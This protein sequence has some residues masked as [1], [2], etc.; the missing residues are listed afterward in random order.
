[1]IKT[2]QWH[3]WQLSISSWFAPSLSLEIN[4]N[5]DS[6]KLTPNW[7][8]IW[9]HQHTLISTMNLIKK[10]T[11]DWRKERSLCHFRGLARQRLNVPMYWGR[12]LHLSPSDQPVFPIPWTKQLVEQ[13]VSSP[14]LKIKITAWSVTPSYGLTNEKDREGPP[15][16]SCECL[17]VPFLAVHS[18]LAPYVGMPLQDP[19]DCCYRFSCNNCEDCVRVF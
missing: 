10:T 8:Q 18:A 9:L 2:L 11:K 15:N 4:P 12:A 3:W 1:M 6:T 14:K 17:W 16:H 5:S 7:L 19:G 13:S